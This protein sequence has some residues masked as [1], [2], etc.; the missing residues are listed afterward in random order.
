MA[1]NLVFSIEAE[2]DAKSAIFYYDQIHPDLRERFFNE[3]LKIYDKLSTAPQYYSYITTV[4]KSE[5]RDVQMPS[6]PYVVI[7]S[8]IKNEVYIIA[9]RNTRRIPLFS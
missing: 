6:F 1:Y 9:V 3:L 7:F 2:E 8:I 5:I 4:R